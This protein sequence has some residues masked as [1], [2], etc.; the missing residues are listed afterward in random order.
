MSSLII[1]LY[2]NRTLKLRYNSQWS[3]KLLEDVVAK[4]NHRIHFDAYFKVDGRWRKCQVTSGYRKVWLPGH[5]HPYWLLVS[6]CSMPDT[7]W[8]NLV[9]NSCSPW[10]AS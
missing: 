9:S 8:T 3:E 4:I 10:E 2:H 5:E 1:R 7:S 6:H